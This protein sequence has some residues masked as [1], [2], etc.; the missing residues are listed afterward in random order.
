MAE[1][2][3]DLSRKHKRMKLVYSKI[4]IYTVLTLGSMLMI[5]PFVW[6]ITTS[7]KEPGAVFTFPPEFIPRTQI[8]TEYNG[9][10]HGLFKVHIEGKDELVIKIKVFKDDADVMIY[11]DGNGR[12][13]RCTVR[14]PGCTTSK[15]I[16]RAT[17]RLGAYAF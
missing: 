1:L 4:L 2:N 7:L 8:M 5:A 16:L 11:R 14:I 13:V 17:V 10:E 6:M 12:M 15:R 9:I 3:R